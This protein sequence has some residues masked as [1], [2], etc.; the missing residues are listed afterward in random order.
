VRRLFFPT[1][2][3][4]AASCVVAASS[5]ALPIPAAVPVAAPARQTIQGVGAGPASTSEL[6]RG[7]TPGVLA[8]T[9][10]PASG[11]VVR[12]LSV[13]P[14]PVGPPPPTEPGAPPSAPVSQPGD[15]SAPVPSSGPHSS[16]PPA[17]TPPVKNL[18]ITGHGYG[19]GRGLGQWGAFGYA[20]DKGWDYRRI[21]G[22]YYSNTGVGKLSSDSA[23]GVRLTG[24]DSKPVAIV[25]Q[26]GQLFLTINGETVGPTGATPPPAEAPPSSSATPTQPAKPGP[27]AVG[28]PPA[29]L[30]G[31]TAPGTGQPGA[32]QPGASTP[33]SA[34]PSTVPAILP[35]SGLPNGSVAVVRVQL[36]GAGRFAISESSSCAGP[37]V[38]RGTV[39]AASVTVSPV[40]PG[41]AVAETGKD[42]SGKD[43]P[44]AMLQVCT[45]A[46][47]RVYRG[48]LAVVDGKPNQY[49]VNQIDMEEYL[50]SVV[51]A[52]VPSGWGAKPN[53]MEALK[54][55]AVAARSYAAA[56]KRSGFANTCDTTACQVYSGRGEYRNG[57]FASYEDARTDEA[58]R[59]TAD[60]IRATAQGTAVRTEFSSSTGGQS[61]PGGG[62]PPVIDEGDKTAAN[63][64]ATWTVTL[65]ASRLEAGRKLGAF[66]DV[67]IVLRDGVGPYGG[68]VQ[69]L[70]LIFERGKVALKSGEFL[71]AYN[72]RSVLFKV[73]VV[74]AGTGAPAG[75]TPPPLESIPAD[76][77]SGNVGLANPGAVVEPTPS[78]IAPPTTVAGKKK[79][80]TTK[81]IK[82]KGTATV[83]PVGVEATKPVKPTTTV[84]PP[85]KSAGKKK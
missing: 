27:V 3:V 34:V 29:T 71:R 53:G 44:A 32:G 51:P 25:H 46:G 14:V 74:D 31:G 73:D 40:A 72:L 60:E 19:H 38:P 11:P 78:T 62:F 22:H 13:T 75:A 84:K 1:A 10:G 83:Q 35:P 12:G 33:D 28:V 76:G 18:V 36:V 85:A 59:A 9:P 61:A 4:L 68:R 43:N 42:N 20:V 26:T 82:P 79:N 45:S 66:K 52:E 23:V 57:G 54:A 63:P 21:L 7:T 24:F 69:N 81:P 80:T 65:A 56:E 30:T 49:L 58:I 64:H 6:Q 67:E 37:W 2:A 70:N 17:T 47:R 8:S 5:S 77:T 15:S 16:A 41:Q 55:Q 39:S 48:K 50:R